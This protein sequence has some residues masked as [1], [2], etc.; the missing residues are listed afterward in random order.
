MGRQAKEKK[1]TPRNPLSW[2]PKPSLRYYYGIESKKVNTLPRLNYGSLSPVPR[3]PSLA[4]RNPETLPLDQLMSALAD[5]EKEMKQAA[6]ALEFERAAELRDELSR[7][8]KL[9]PAGAKK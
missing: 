8:K 1:A 4:R 6:R 2:N 5:I 7:L 3:P 9:L